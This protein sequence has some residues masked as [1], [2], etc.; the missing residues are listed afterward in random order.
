MISFGFSHFIFILKIRIRY[1]NLCAL[2]EA[3]VHLELVL[4]CVCCHLTDVLPQSSCPPGGPL[5]VVCPVRG[6]VMW[7]VFVSWRRLRLTEVVAWL[8]SVILKVNQRSKLQNYF[9]LLCIMVEWIF[10]HYSRKSIENP[11]YRFTLCHYVKKIMWISRVKKENVWSNCLKVKQV[12]LLVYDDSNLK[13]LVRDSINVVWC[14]LKV[15]VV[16]EAV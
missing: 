1:L 7:V 11:N 10:V 13:N 9:G 12:A 6:A 3:F 5:R 4:G 16:K 14:P 15:C 2:H 8:G